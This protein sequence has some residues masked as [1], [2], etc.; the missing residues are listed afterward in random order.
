MVQV[1]SY[2]SVVDNSGIK[3]VKCIKLLGVGLR[4]FARVGDVVLVS[5]QEGRFR[6]FKSDK[7][8]V[9]RGVI[10]SVKKPVKRLGGEIIRFDKNSVVLVKGDNS[11]IGTRVLSPVMNELRDK[12]FMKIISLALISI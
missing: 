1:G 7:Q 10:V 2:L 5:I 3:T 6:R 9:C 4:K 12:K 11:P 8:K